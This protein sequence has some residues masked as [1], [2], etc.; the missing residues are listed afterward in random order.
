V[1]LVIDNYDS[2]VY[3][4]AQ[5]LGEMGWEPLVC[6]NDQITP[7]EA[8]AMGPSHIIISPGP[9]TPRQAGVSSDMIRSFAGRVPVLGVC[10]GH[11]CIGEVYGGKTVH[12]PMPVHGKSSLI[13]HDNRGIYTGLPNPIEGGR[14]HSLAVELGKAESHLEVTASCEGVIM[15]LRHR[16]YTVEGIQFHPESVMTPAGHQ[17]LRNFLKYSRGLWEEERT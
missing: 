1:I 12:A 11:Q 4:L 13:T 8:M 2:F 7:S 16:V 5:Y 3:N 17:L 14:Y 9:C 10:L 15:G 6:R